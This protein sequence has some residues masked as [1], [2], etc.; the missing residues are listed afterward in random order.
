MRGQTTLSNGNSQPGLAP[1]GPLWPS[2]SGDLHDGP[3]ADLDELGVAERRMLE[4]GKKQQ[5]ETTEAA[6]RALQVSEQT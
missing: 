4:R 3:S 1:V 6:N 2:H 5:K